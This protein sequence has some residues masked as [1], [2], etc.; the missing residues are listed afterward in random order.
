MWMNLEGVIQ[1]EVSQK[2]TNKY[3]TLMH[4]CEIW[5][6][7]IGGITCK[8]EME[9]Q[10]EY[11]YGYRGGGWGGRTRETWIDKYALLILCIKQTTNGI[12]CTAQGSLLN[13]L[14]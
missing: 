8:A 4:I 12:F 9:T 2:E 14:W 7:C 1:S 10:T 11:M 3:H 6:N 13:A 5:K